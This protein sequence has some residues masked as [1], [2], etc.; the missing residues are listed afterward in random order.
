MKRNDE[1]AKLNKSKSV[2]AATINYS[3][4]ARLFLFEDSESENRT[5]EHRRDRDHENQNSIL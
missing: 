2:F 5:I 4:P 3:V 1:E